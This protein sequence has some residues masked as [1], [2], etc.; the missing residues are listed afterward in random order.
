MEGR[1]RRP[2]VPLVPGQLH[3]AGGE[4]AGLGGQQRQPGVSR[5][6]QER[7]VQSAAAF[8]YFLSIAVERI[9]VYCCVEHKE[10][11]ASHPCF[12]HYLGFTNKQKD[13]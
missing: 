11:S 4:P 1:L 10:Q 7:S 8:I 13:N 3:Q 5:Q 9:R 2:E 6:S 12:D